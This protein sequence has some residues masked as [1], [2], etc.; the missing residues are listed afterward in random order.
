V[1]NCSRQSGQPGWIP[2]DVN[3]DGIVSFLDVIA[4]GNG[5]GEVTDLCIES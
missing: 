5:F 4:V 1:I 2:E 3:K